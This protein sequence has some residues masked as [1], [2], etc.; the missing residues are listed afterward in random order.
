M[1]VCVSH[2]QHML[3]QSQVSR[4]T[5]VAVAQSPHLHILTDLWVVG[6]FL[7]EGAGMIM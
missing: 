7:W 2:H 3:Q 1:C 6:G 4:C 5:L